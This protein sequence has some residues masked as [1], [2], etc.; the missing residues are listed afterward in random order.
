MSFINGFGYNS[1]STT[2]YVWTIP[3][4]WKFSSGWA[5]GLVH[6][7]KNQ[8]DWGDFW[9]GVLH[10]SL[11]KPFD[12]TLGGQLVIGKKDDTDYWLVKLNSK[13]KDIGVE[14]S[15]KKGIELGP[16]IITELR[17]SFYHHMTNRDKLE[18]SGNVNDVNM[19]EFDSTYSYNDFKNGLPSLEE[20]EFEDYAAFDLD[21]SYYG[22][23][24]FLS[25][26]RKYDVDNSTAYGGNLR[27]QL[28]DKKTRGE[29]LTSSLATDLEFTSSGDVRSVHFQG[30]VGLSNERTTGSKRK[31][32]IY[33]DFIGG[34]DIYYH[35][36][37]KHLRGKISVQ[38][39]TKKEGSKKKPVPFCIKANATFE[40]TPDFWQLDIGN[41]YDRIII[42]KGCLGMKYQG[43]LGFGSKRLD[44]G[45]G[46]LFHRRFETGWID[47]EIA[48]FNAA[49]E[50]G[51][52]TTLFV[53]FDINPEFRFREGGVELETWANVKV[54]YQSF[55]HDG[56]IDLIDA[57]LR[58][59][60]L[61][62]D[63]N[64]NYHFKGA[65]NGYAK[66]LGVGVGFKLNTTVQM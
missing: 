8:G 19:E 54:D 42:D 48:K 43:W 37:G 22:S 36:G 59:I 10:V 50:I 35:P 66:V 26:T 58:G 57:R 18:I 41:R 31:T 51:F 64:G 30:S 9:Q 6:Y 55:F 5:A 46:I 23:E 20:L 24:D 34:A 45:L 29:Y 39:N 28:I 27:I 65:L 61:F 3:I 16:V 49:A 25:A 33:S 53:G 11:K 17:G 56:S 47:L 21:K 13:S 44:A 62:R 4:A 32:K 40:S 15:E 2:E 63:V 1:E 52:Q 60:L 38:T 14:T 12:A 7:V